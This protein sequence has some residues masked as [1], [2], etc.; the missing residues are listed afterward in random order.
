MSPKCS[1][2]FLFLLCTII[3]LEVCDIEQHS[4]STLSDTAANLGGGTTTV[5]VWAHQEKL[6][7]RRIGSKIKISQRSESKQTIVIIL[8]W[9]QTIVNNSILISGSMVYESACRGV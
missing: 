8:L 3:Q 5:C 4:K 7:E 6:N 1:F 9:F 2:F